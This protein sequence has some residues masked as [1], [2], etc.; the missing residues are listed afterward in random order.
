MVCNHRTVWETVYI[1]VKIK[2]RSHLTRLTLH[3]FC[4]LIS[5][6]GAALKSRGDRTCLTSL[7][8]IH[9]LHNVWRQHHSG[10]KNRYYKNNTASAREAWAKKIFKHFQEL[11]R[12]AL[13]GVQ[14]FMKS[15]CMTATWK[16][17]HCSCEI[18]STTTAKLFSSFTD[19]MCKRLLY[20]ASNI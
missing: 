16:I 4:A 10:R 17:K 11:C 12:P 9:I 5:A 8:N 2:N 13:Y 14:T 20:R 18:W 1:L 19:T 7:Y 15:L 3:I 6:N